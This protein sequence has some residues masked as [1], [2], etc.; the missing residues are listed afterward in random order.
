MVTL[1]MGRYQWT[2][3]KL[4]AVYYQV[5]SVSSDSIDSMTAKPMRD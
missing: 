2:V 4:V 3:G 1:L 5:V